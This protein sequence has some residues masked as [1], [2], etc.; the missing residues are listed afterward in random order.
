[1]PKVVIDGID[2]E[3]EP[4]TTILK[5]AESV[6]I[7][8]PA[9]CYHPYLKPAGICRMCLVEVEGIPRFFPACITEV[10][11]GWVIHTDS[12][13][14][15]DARKW[16]LEFLLVRHPLDCPICDQAGDCEL[17]D[18]VFKYGASE[19]RLFDKRFDYPT[20]YL[21]PLIVHQMSRCVL[22]RRCVRFDREVVGGTS[23]GVYERGPNS[24]VG[25]YESKIY[26][27]RY[28][29]NME[30]LC[31]V[32]AI[33][34]AI[35]R[36]KTRIWK[37]DFTPS[38]CAH[39]EVGCNLMLGVRENQL[40]KVRH[41]LS[42]HPSCWSC[43][44]G[45][46]GF[47][48][49]NHPERMSYPLIREGNKMKSVLWSEIKGVIRDRLINLS[50]QNVAAIVSPSLTCE[51]Y[52]LM[53]R[54][55]QETVGSDLMD[56]RTDGSRTYPEKGTVKDL[57]EIESASSIMVV[58]EDVSIHHPVL[59]LSIAKA[60]IDNAAHLF[61]VNTADIY[62][63]KFS[64][65]HPNP[66]PG[67][68]GAVLE[69][70]YKGVKGEDIPES[71]LSGSGIDLEILRTMTTEIKEKKPLLIGGCR[72]TPKEMSMLKEMS[73]LL[74]VPILFLDNGA[75]SKGAYGMGFY[76][77]KGLGVKEILQG[78]IKGEIK[79]LF[80]SCV[81]L[82]RDYPNRELVKE[83]LS[84]VEFLVVHD[85]FFTETAS[86]ADCFIPSTSFAEY[87]GSM[88]NMLWNLQHKE[89]A[90]DP[91]GECKPLWEVALELSREMDKSL[92]DYASISDLK[93]EVEKNLEIER[94]SPQLSELA[95][96]IPLGGD[97]PTLL[98]EP[99]YRSGI[100]ADW[101]HAF[102]QLEPEPS[103]S[104]YPDDAEA[105]DLKDGDKALI[106]ANGFKY[107]MRVKV[108][109]EV[110]KGGAL[111]SSGFSDFPITAM[112]KGSWVTRINI[113]KLGE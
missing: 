56:Y 16:L 33:T 108:M 96:E 102:V 43:D 3:V 55:M 53:A 76:S 35:Y 72:L 11:D 106:E 40:L 50:P 10:Q 49:V 112:V 67:F 23:W 5:A 101:C 110:P 42:P 60:C 62:L 8:I 84:S 45:Y 17:Q 69:A 51:D 109:D 4:G 113:S 54:F 36:Y 30:E 6:G 90:M 41:M 98:D 70:I 32:G 26:A 31:P 80:I 64:K 89:K 1:M 14:V 104:L 88:V 44:K 75:N 100:Y 103:V 86:Y 9:F 29:C 78:V 66:L 47:E 38:L 46:Y 18:F 58:G 48:Y 92:G 111:I 107:Q 57:R 27:S 73:V 63:C 68:Q 99:F 34:S 105:M 83:A 15:R 20:Q 7:D 74:N 93:D 71:L 28:T 95:Y 25:P 39:C 97:I 82:F 22:C 37:L 13:H 19:Q 59:A 77:T 65:H 94:Y 61:L 52:M 91:K 2:V 87:G 12:E 81:D 21:G 85:L 79:G 24:I